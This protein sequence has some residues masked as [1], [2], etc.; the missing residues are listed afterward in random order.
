MLEV[1]GA[2]PLNVQ[3]D[4]FKGYYFKNDEFHCRIYD[5]KVR[6]LIYLPKCDFETY[7]FTWKNQTLA[8]YF[9][10]CIQFY[11]Y[12]HPE[13]KCICIEDKLSVDCGRT[14]N[15]WDEPNGGAQYMYL[16]NFTTAFFKQ[17]WFVRYMNAELILRD[18]EKDN[19]DKL[20]TLDE[21]IK[22]GTSSAL[23]VMSRSFIYLHDIAEKYETIFK[24]CTSVY[25]FFKCFTK[26]SRFKDG[27][28]WI[29]GYIH[30]Q[31][32]PFYKYY[33]IPI[34]P[35]HQTSS[36]YD[37]VIVEQTEYF[38]E[39]AFASFEGT[40]DEIVIQNEIVSTMHFSAED[41]D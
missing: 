19:K 12:K 4:K 33:K 41:A 20:C 14:T 28:P 13:K 9:R 26:R 34:H 37:S 8:R 15:L 17:S 36:F 16:T 39:Y 7:M 30:H 11:G 40:A 35:I 18:Y 1:Q 32:R 21:V 25:D 24:S 22:P 31:I 5:G 38:D 2:K 3:C 29:A 10:A 27:V 23:Q 6:N